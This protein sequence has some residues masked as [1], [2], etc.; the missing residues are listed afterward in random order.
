MGRWWRGG[1]AGR[2]GVGQR[3]GREDRVGERRGVRNGGNM[4]VSKEQ[5]IA[6][7]EGG[8]SACMDKR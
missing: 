7:S 3:E 1:G 6:D 4:I 8:L 2:K 5:D